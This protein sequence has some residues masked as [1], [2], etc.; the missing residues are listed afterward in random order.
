MQTT[1]TTTTT[2]PKKVNS[3]YLHGKMQQKQKLE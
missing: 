2:K 3:K 1:T